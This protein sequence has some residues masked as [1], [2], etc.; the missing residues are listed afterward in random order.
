[1]KLLES[2]RSDPKKQR[3]WL[4]I[5]AVVI[6]AAGSTMLDGIWQDGAGIAARV[7]VW[8]LIYAFLGAALLGQMKTAFRA[9]L[10]GAL[11]ALLAV[12]LWIRFPLMSYASK[13]YVD[14]LGE[15]TAA[16][17]QIP[18]LR[19]LGQTIGDYNAPYFYLLFLIA[20]AVPAAG[21]L[22]WI[23]LFSVAFEA[24]GA[25]AVMRLVALATPRR[26]AQLGSLFAVLLLPGVILNGSAWGQCD[27]V[28]T[29]LGL[30][31]VYYGLNRQSKLSFLFFAL[32]FSF[33]LQTVFFLPVALALL[34]TERI[35]LR[36]VWVF[37]A[38]FLVLLLPA[39]LAGRPVLETVSI[40]YKQAAYYEWLHMNAPTIFGFFA[41]ETGLASFATAGVFAAGAVVLALVSY[42]YL[43]RN[44]LDTARMLDAA[45]LSLLIIPFFLPHMHERYFFAADVMGAVYLARHP[46]RWYLPVAAATASFLCYFEFLFDQTPAIP[47]GV[48]SLAMAVVIGTILSDLIRSLETDGGHAL[49]EACR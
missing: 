49:R 48:L 21:E 9:D 13:D 38:V 3:N 24:V 19:S 42:L 45:Y 14:C 4:L 46:R 34:F 6:F 33:K 43:R 40:Y 23:K 22:Y 25:V 27:M 11:L 28:Y 10:F 39:V 17:R 15:W 18:G 31:A 20:K 30:L 26:L 2:V 36:D 1:M 41:P 44:R 16:I 35:R 47:L 32:A 5:G 7:F 29:A 8:A 37:F 12:T